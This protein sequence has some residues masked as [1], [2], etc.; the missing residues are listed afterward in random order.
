MENEN[1]FTPDESGRSE[2]IVSGTEIPK[3]EIQ[4]GA[5]EY[6]QGDSLWLDFQSGDDAEGIKSAGVE[7]YVISPVTE[8]DLFSDKYLNC[9]GVVGIGRD[10]TS[11]KEIAFISHQDPEYFLNK[12]SEETS[13]F[14]NDLRM[15]LNELLTRSEEGTI[16]V[17]LVGGNDD[18]ADSESK[19]TVDYKKSITILT[20]IV[21]SILG[22]A[23]TIPAEA[24]H[25]GGAVDVRVFTQDRK[26]FVDKW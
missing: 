12:G 22:V 26:V 17:V 7:T 11:G 21:Q 25:E 1:N 23:P 18:P 9:T 14:S 2:K 19:K 15:T 10:K 24:N 13:R 8:R 3:I 16:E 20:E 5:P 6:E 4:M